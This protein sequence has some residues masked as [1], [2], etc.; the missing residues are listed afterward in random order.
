M[1]VPLLVRFA[2][3][4]VLLMLTVRWLAPLLSRIASV[5]APER[6]AVAGRSKDPKTAGLPTV[7]SRFR[8]APDAMVP[9]P[10]SSV[11]V[12]AG[13]RSVRTPTATETG[14]DRVG[15]CGVVVDLGRPVGDERATVDHQGG[16]SDGDPDGSRAEGSRLCV[17]VGRVGDDV[18]SSERHDRRNREHP[19]I[20]EGCG[21]VEVPGR[22]RH[23]PAVG[24]GHGFR[25]ASRSRR[26]RSAIAPLPT[27]SL[28]LPE[29][30]P[31]VLPVPDARLMSPGPVM[32]PVENRKQPVQGQVGVQ[33]DLV[34]RPLGRSPIVEGCLS[35]RSRH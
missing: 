34:L 4:L 13:G 19:V 27:A 24:D 35:R 11:V 26:S 29:M 32:A 25:P 7:L 6:L 30:F 15:C 20:G 31:L 17:P 12:L 23:R 9:P 1:R 3:E 28:P 2:T 10:V 5:P 33:G 8:V 22:D 14:P 18:V 16:A 21:A